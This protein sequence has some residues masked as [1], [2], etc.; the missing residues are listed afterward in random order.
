MSWQVGRTPF[1]ATRNI[2]RP[3][4]LAAVLEE[5]SRGTGLGY[6]WETTI[7]KPNWFSPHPAN[8]TGACTLDLVL[9][10]VP[11]TKLV[12]ESHS[13]GRNFGGCEVTPANGRELLPWIREQER[14]FLERTGLEEVLRRHGVEYVNA[15]EEVWGGRA[16]PAD[17][18]RRIVEGRAGPIGHPE[19]YGQVPLRLFELRDRAVLLDLAKIKVE[20]GGGAFSLAIKNLFG[21]IV[22][23]NR[24]D[25]HTGLPGSIV[26]IACVYL[27]LFPV[28]GVAEGIFELVRGN[29]QGEVPAPWGNYDVER[30]A[31]LVVAGWP[32]SDVDLAAGRALG[33]DLAGR[34]LARLARFRE[35]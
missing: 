29:P 17:D 16:A 18:V 15:T 34:A 11:G 2:A 22:E 21:L 9:A 30:D 28:V 23:P 33:L 4:Q 13:C 35:I 24:W 27:S 19:L 3:D 7:I 25:Y 12:V 6:P 10:A 1:V 8:F 5:V 14:V 32:L 20:P 31:G 26:D